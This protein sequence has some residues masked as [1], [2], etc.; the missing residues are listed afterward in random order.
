VRLRMVWDASDPSTLYWKNEMSIDGRPWALIEEYEMK[1]V[2]PGS[3][4]R[5]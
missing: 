3:T 1:P 4:R 5:S 2:Q